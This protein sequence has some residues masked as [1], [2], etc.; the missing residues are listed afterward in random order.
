MKQNNALKEL[1]PYYRTYRRKFLTN[2]ALIILRIGCVTLIPLL[3]RQ[4]F[5]FQPDRMWEYMGWIGGIVLSIIGMVWCSYEIIRVGKEIGASI[6]TDLR[7]D[8]FAHLQKLNFSYYDTHKTGHLMA[9]MTN[10]LGTLSGT[11]H[12]LPEDLLNTLLT[13]LGALAVMFWMNAPLALIAVVPLPVAVWMGI[14]SKK[15][16]KMHSHR[17]R[18]DIGWI[19][20]TMENSIMGIREVQSFANEELQMAEF[21]KINQ[22]FCTA[23]F[24]LAKTAAHYAAFMLGFMRVHGLMITVAGSLMC[25]FFD[26]PIADLIAFM[27]YTRFMIMPIERLVSFSD[28]YAQG[29]AA[30]E[31]FTEILDTKPEIENDPKA[32]LPE[33]VCGS[34]QFDEVSF[35]YNG[36]ERMVLNQVNLNVEPGSVIALVGESGAGKSTLANLVCRFYEATSGRVLLDGADVKTWPLHGLRRQIGVVQ[37]VPFLFDSSIRHNIAFGRPEASEAELREAARQANILEFIDSLPDGLDTMV[38]EQGVMLSGGQR[39]R[40]SIARVFL[41]NPPIIIFDEATSSLDNESERLMQEAMQHLFNGRTTLI[42]AHRLSTVK[43]ADYTYVFREGRIE[44]AGT[45]EALMA[46][47]GYYHQLYTQGL[48]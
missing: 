18:A 4:L 32:M 40:I 31:R 38:G 14:R 36:T 15:K 5:N 23:K 30:F 48:G 21:E 46:A 47:E 35:A 16:F 2:I 11:L 42:I 20:S 24:D 3:T 1:V 27:M 43:Y 45:H 28:Q 13:L 41:K 17:I 12:Q 44:E 7:R 10:D 39:Q 37:Q 33:R 9:R 25:V 29:L 26:L 19:N 8:L 6:E 22:R 34:L